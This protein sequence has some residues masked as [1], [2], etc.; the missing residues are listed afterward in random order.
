MESGSSYMESLPERPGEVAVRREP[1]VSINDAESEPIT[2]SVDAT[3]GVG[4]VMFTR[5][6]RVDAGFFGI[7]PLRAGPL[8]I[9]DCADLWLPYRPVI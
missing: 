2:D 1:G 8:T 5:E 7:H 9:H 6:E 4:S 3:D